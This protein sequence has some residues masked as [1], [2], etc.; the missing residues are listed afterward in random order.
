[1]NNCR[2]AL[3]FRFSGRDKVAYIHNNANTAFGNI[4]QWISEVSD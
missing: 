3:G 4:A 1:M 2:G